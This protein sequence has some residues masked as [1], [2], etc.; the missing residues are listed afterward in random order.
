MPKL[1]SH[2]HIRSV[3]SSHI[4]YEQIQIK[5][6]S[7]ICLYL[8]R[9]HSLWYDS[10]WQRECHQFKISK[11][12]LWMK[13]LMAKKLKYNRKWECNSLSFTRIIFLTPWMPG[14]HGLEVER[15]TNRSTGKC[16]LHGEEAVV[17]ADCCWHGFSFKRCN[18]YWPGR[19]PCNSNCCIPRALYFHLRMRFH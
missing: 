7:L 4:A 5:I 8:C 19:I 2:I 3:N 16:P 13:E 18:V 1:C 10:I 11:F 14:V 17:L 15:L 12:K 6:S 9:D